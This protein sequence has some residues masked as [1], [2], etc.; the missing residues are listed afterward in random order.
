M[1]LGRE[2]VSAAVR[3]PGLS[4]VAQPFNTEILELDELIHVE[5]AI[6]ATVGPYVKR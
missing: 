4:E 3:L 1:R 6:G 2:G 5:L